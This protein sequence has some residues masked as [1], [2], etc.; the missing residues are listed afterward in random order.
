M[1]R[2]IAA[3]RV[4]GLMGGLVLLVALSAC[5]GD[6]A[7]TFG[8]Q[9]D[10]PDEFV[11]TRRAPLSLPP[12]YGLRPPVPGS[13]RPQEL[14]GRDAGEAALLGV[15]ALAGPATTVTPG[16]QALLAGAGSGPAVPSDD[17]RRRVDEESRRL[18]L[19]DRGLSDRLIFWRDRQPAGV[20]VDPQAEAQRLRAN[21]A[22]GQA[23]GTGETQIIQRRRQ[24][25]LESLF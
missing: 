24:G 3:R 6:T 16:E 15:T 19:A 8:F 10:P 17:L 9:R 22:L 23:P 7:R 1:R 14:T 2:G 25:L 13:P 4:G 20:A 12:N 5:G 21:A 18:D 11:S